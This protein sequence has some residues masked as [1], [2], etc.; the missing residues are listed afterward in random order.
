[1]RLVFGFAKFPRKKFVRIIMNEITPHMKATSISL[2]IRI[3]RN[4]ANIRP[5]HTIIKAGGRV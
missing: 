2:M 1:M 5:V 3:T 4:S